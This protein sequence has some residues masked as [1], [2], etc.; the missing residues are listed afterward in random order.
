MQTGESD[1]QAFPLFF[2]LKVFKSLGRSTDLISPRLPSSPILVMSKQQ[3]LQCLLEDQIVLVC[4]LID[5]HGSPFETTVKMKPSLIIFR[6]ETGGP[7][8]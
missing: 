1:L 5:P 7:L 3:C 6:V 8:P 2:I 4:L